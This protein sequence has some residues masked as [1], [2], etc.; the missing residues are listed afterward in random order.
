MP[1]LAL[2]IQGNGLWQDAQDV[3]GAVFAWQAVDDSDGLTHDS[4]ATRFKLPR[5]G[6]SFTGLG[7]ASFPLFLQAEGLIPTSI[8]INVAARRT[9]AGNPGILI[10]LSRGGSVSLDGTVFSPGVS[11]TVETRTFT[12]NPF[13]GAAWKAS[14]LVG[15]EACVQSELGAFAGSNQVTLISGSIDYMGDHFWRGLRPRAITLQG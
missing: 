4:D 3:T 9:G 15:L 10:G 12:V 13:T 2:K 14:D 7:I 8:S 6:Q 1:T 11:Y 5:A